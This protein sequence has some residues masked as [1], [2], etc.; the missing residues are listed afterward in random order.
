MNKQLFD[1]LQIY[2]LSRLIMK[3][4][5]KSKIPA[6]FINYFVYRLINIPPV[7]VFVI[8]FIKEIPDTQVQAQVS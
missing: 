8:V 7:Q 6:R 2:E 3:F 5:H 4:N 1:F